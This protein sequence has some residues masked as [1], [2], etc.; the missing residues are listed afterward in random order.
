MTCL[1]GL[2][3]EHIIN[4]TEDEYSIYISSYIRLK[5][6]VTMEENL[7]AVLGNYIEYESFTLQLALKAFISD[8]VN[9]LE[10]FWNDILE[11]ER[12]FLNFLTSSSLYQERLLN[13]IKIL[14]IAETHQLPSNNFKLF[15]QL[16]DHIQHRGSISVNLLSDGR[17]NED[18]TKL[19]FTYKPRISK[20]TLQKI[21]KSLVN[22]AFF[23]N[24][25]YFLITPALRDYIDELIE[26]HKITMLNLKDMIK[27]DTKIINSIFSRMRKHCYR[28]KKV[29]SIHLDNDINPIEINKNFIKY[30]TEIAKTNSEIDKFKFKSIRTEA[31][32]I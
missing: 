13:H 32:E 22:N 10:D 16:R 15:T 6:A 5:N 29:D 11:V 24:E 9:T 12:K 27:S 20:E 30:F 18:Q 3:S 25:N 23:N 8:R 7:K 4:L 26:R 2:P 31:L 28:C 17:W 14:N 21:N 19:E 1:K